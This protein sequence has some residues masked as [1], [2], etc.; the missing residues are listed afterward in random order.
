[1]VNHPLIN[2]LPTP[3]SKGA[4]LHSPK[5]QHGPSHTAGW[6]MRAD[7][8]LPAKAGIRVQQSGVFWP[9]PGEPLHE[10]VNSRGASSDHRLVWVKLSLD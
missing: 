2:N 9:A 3:T 8:V 4:A 7:Y 5:N 10:V 6:R 1:L